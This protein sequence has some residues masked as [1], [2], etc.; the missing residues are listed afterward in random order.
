M[1]DLNK[2][3]KLSAILRSFKEE[4]Q[5]AFDTMDSEFG[6]DP[7]EYA[8]MMEHYFFGRTPAYS[9]EDAFEELE[10]AQYTEYLNQQNFCWK[11]HEILAL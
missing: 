6:Y 5:A 2:P 10:D 11:Y 4:R 1:C 9:I 7:T 3:V 8:W